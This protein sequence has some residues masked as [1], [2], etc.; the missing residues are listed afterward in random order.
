MPRQ[1]RV[2][3]RDFQVDADFLPSPATK[4][5]ITECFEEF[6]GTSFWAWLIVAAFF[7]CDG[8]PIWST[9]VFYAQLDTDTE[10][11]SDETVPQGNW[12]SGDQDQAYYSDTAHNLQHSLHQFPP[13]GQFA[14]H[15]FCPTP[16]PPY[17]SIQPP[18]FWDPTHQGAVPGHWQASFEPSLRRWVHTWQPDF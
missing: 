4:L 17:T 6:P 9:E 13:T 18:N 5:V 12:P 16:F 15:N 11:D 1:P 14:S 10:S 8:R 2:R 7:D 3:H